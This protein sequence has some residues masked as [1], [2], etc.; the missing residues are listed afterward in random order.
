[1]A[2][3]AFFG[4]EFLGV[5]GS[6]FRRENEAQSREGESLNFVMEVISTVPDLHLIW[7]REGRTLIAVQ[8]LRG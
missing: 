6:A 7:L 8:P 4:I 3:R 2:T 1:M 5:L